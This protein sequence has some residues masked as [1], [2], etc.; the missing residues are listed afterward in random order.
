M[1]KTSSGPRRDLVKRLAGRFSAGLGDWLGR[2]AGASVGILCYHRVSPRYYG[3]PEPTINVTPARFRAQLRGLLAMGFRFW[4]L[5]RLLEHHARGSAAPPRTVVVTF[6]DAFASVYHA[7]WPALR[8]LGVPATAFLATAFLD[9]GA[10]FPFDA[11]GTA[12]AGRVPPEAYLPL[13]TQQCRHM[14]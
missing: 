11:W 7:A 14:Q 9:S 3:V 6:D 2:R 13:T 10:P 4:P 1:V 12:Q 5:S 8:E